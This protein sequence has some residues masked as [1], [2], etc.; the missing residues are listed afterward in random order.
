M[1]TIAETNSNMKELFLRKHIFYYKKMKNVD[2]SII[3]LQRIWDKFFITMDLTKMQQFD[4]LSL[5]K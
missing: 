2:F 1:K 5:L 4:R 3:N